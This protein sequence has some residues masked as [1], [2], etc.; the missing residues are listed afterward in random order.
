MMKKQKALYFFV[1]K[2][3]FTDKDLNFLKEEYDVESFNFNFGQKWKTPF[4]LIHQFLFLCWH[5]PTSRFCLI[6]LSG[7]HSWLPCLLSKLMGKKCFIVAAGTDAHCFPSIGYGNYH[8]KLLGYFT[9]SSFRLCTHILPKHDSLWYSKYTYDHSGEPAQGVKQFVPGINDKFTSIPNGYDENVFRPMPVPRDRDFITV[10]G[11]LNRQSQRS[12]K[13]IDLIL[14]MAALF[15]ENSFTIVGVNDESN[16]PKVT[17]N[18]RL[19]PS[20]KNSDL[21]QMFSQHRFYFQL[22]MAEGFPNALC[23]AMLCECTPIGSSVFSIPEIIGDS[24]FVLT[25]RSEEELKAL[26]SKALVSE[27][28]K[29]GK[30]ARKR[31]AEN[32]T[33]LNRK[34]KLLNF[35]KANS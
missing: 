32:Y 24:G 27:T 21:P 13:G 20:V 25:K 10:S 6:Q 7:F 29:L 3:S 17:S 12:L 35:L 8:K 5:L 14:K 26:I 33:L 18:V 16:F 4:Q 19:V 11:L 23:E 31:I 15:P 34:T 1:G 30:E 9:K 22:S 2:S 28:N